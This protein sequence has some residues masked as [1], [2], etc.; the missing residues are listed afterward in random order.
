ME[1]RELRIGN[2]VKYKCCVGDL[3]ESQVDEIKRNGF[4]WCGGWM[5]KEPILLTEEWMV[6]FGFE[7]KGIIKIGEE[8][9]GEIYWYKNQLHISDM[10]DS[11][12]SFVSK[13]EYVHQLQNLYFAL[14]GEEL[15]IK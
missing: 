15:T 13:C 10:R 6:K 3:H 2:Y 5:A 11:S 1:A 8:K 9:D 4:A 12:Y 14:T 7:S